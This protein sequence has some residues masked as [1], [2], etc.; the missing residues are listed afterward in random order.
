MT[1]IQVELPPKGPLLTKK[2]YDRLEQRGIK[3]T[4]PW[5]IIEAADDCARE[6]LIGAGARTFARIIEAAYKAAAMRSETNSK[7][8]E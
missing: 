2:D 4:T 6:V 7:G 8:T 5:W 1:K 3:A